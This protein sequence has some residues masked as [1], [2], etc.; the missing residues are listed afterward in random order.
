M[1][2][3]IV[4]LLVVAIILLGAAVSRPL[5]WVAIGV[6]VLALLI[7]LFGAWPGGRHGDAGPRGFSAVRCV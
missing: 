3:A 7:A 4:V 2:F 5:G 1:T 6:A